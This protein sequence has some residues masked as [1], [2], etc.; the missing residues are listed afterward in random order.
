MVIEHARNGCSPVMDKGS[1]TFRVIE[2]MDAYICRHHFAV[3]Y[4]FQKINSS[5]VRNGKYLGE[6]LTLV[7]YTFP[8]GKMVQ[9]AFAH[10]AYLVRVD[11][12]VGPD[13]VFVFCQGVDVVFHG[14]VGITDN[15]FQKTDYLL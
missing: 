9:D 11:V 6:P 1:S 3:F 5:E 13:I 15:L 14:C 7:D 2:G 12:F 4:L 8:Q 10:G